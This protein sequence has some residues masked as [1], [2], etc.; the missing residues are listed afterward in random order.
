M[1]EGLGTFWPVSAHLSSEG[2]A[3]FGMVGDGPAIRSGDWLLAPDRAGEGLTVE[4]IFFYGRRIEQAEAT[5]G[6]FL[7]ISGLNPDWVLPEELL[8]FG[9]GDPHLLGDEFSSQS[10]IVLWSEEMRSDPTAGRRQLLDVAA[11]S[12]LS[13]A[14]SR[15]VGAK[16]A[17]LSW[18]GMLGVPDQSKWSG[19]VLAAFKGA[20]NLDGLEK[21]LSRSWA[22][23]SYR[24]EGAEPRDSRSASNSE[25]FFPDFELGK[26]AAGLLALLAD[27]PTLAREETLRVLRS[28]DHE[29][30][31]KD[32][33]SLI[34]LLARMFW[35]GAIDSGVERLLHYETRD[36]FL[37]MLPPSGR[38]R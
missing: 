17:Q 16:L 2:P 11:H 36:A 38:P 5:Y 21:R 12:S 1:N 4:S 22:D 19:A 6:C 13:E 24:N 10:Q 8:Y 33:T 32:R 27:D 18:S 7:V 37:G 15:Y 30:T 31:P 35:V 3:V 29:V 34:S 9:R 20:C 28:I 14:C 25:A 23:L 26:D